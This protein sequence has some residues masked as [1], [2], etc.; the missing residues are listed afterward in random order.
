S[1]FETSPLA[2]AGVRDVDDLAARVKQP[3]ML[4]SAERNAVSLVATLRAAAASPGALARAL[5]TDGVD[6]GNVWQSMFVQPMGH[7]DGQGAAPSA[8]TDRVLA[9]V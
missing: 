1:P 5:A 3:A 8:L 7:L 4:G 6:V 2:L 9:A